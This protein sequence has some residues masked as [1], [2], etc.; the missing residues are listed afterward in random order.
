MLLPT[1]AGWAFAIKGCA[2]HLRKFWFVYLPVA[3]LFAWAQ[4]HYRVGV[5]VTKSLPYRL[6][7]VALDERPSK[8]GEFVS[9]EWRRDQFYQPDFLFTKKIVGVAG[10]KITVEGQDV[11]LDGQL[12][13]HAKTVS[14]H[15][16]P[17][18]TIE[19]GVIPPGQF[20]VLAT[21]P[22]SLDSRYKVTG[23][24]GEDRIVGKAYVLF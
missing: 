5:N 3:A 12:V 16:V 9:F 8:V 23:L 19:P 13:A 2:R 21:H 4:A 7:F 20:F 17:L 10:Q 18:Q 22:D 11:Y 24:V 15:G 14:S 1:R 6:F